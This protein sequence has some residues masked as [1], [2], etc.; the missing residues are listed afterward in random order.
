MTGGVKEHAPVLWLRLNIGLSSAD[1]EHLLFTVVEVDDIKIKVRLLWQPVG[2]TRW[3]MV[4]IELKPHVA[5]RI[6]V[7]PHPGHIL[8][9]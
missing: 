2:P 6:D 9:L 4:G 5:R 8:G 1:A 7:Q 3:L